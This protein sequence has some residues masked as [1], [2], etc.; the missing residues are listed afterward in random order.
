MDAHNWINTK[1]GMELHAGNSHGE[2][3]NEN[4]IL[5]LVEFYM[6]KDMLG[7]LTE[8]DKAMFKNICINLQSYDKATG[9]QVPGIYDRGEKE[10]LELDSEALRTPSHDNMTAI[11]FFSY[12]HGM[13]FHK[14]MAK[15]GYRHFFRWDNRNIDKPAWDRFQHPRDII[16][17]SYI[18]SGLLGKIFWG[19]FLPLAALMLFHSCWKI[20][21]IRGPNKFRHTDGKLLTFVRVWH[22][23]DIAFMK[24]TGWICHKILEKRWGETYFKEIF[25]TYFRDPAHPNRALARQVQSSK[26]KWW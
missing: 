10:S 26:L 18:G 24:F 4:G 9:S 11:A 2:R 16:L 5:F 25:S 13:Q 1:H 17:W 3:G 22:C 23:R 20:W 21:K 6:L 12:K 8:D 7:M 19:M 14:D 15:F